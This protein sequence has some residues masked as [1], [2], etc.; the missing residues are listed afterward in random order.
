MISVLAK[1]HRTVGPSFDRLGGAKVRL[2]ER[3]AR[4]L[5]SGR[6]SVVAEILSSMKLHF[7]RI[8][9]FQ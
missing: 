3:T 2:K 8:Q 1:L 5:K 4:A 9:L 6:F 7:L